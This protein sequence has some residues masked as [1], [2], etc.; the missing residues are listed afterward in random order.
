MAERTARLRSNLNTLTR[1][2]GTGFVASV[3]GGD[4]KALSA[5]IAEAKQAEIPAECN[6]AAEQRLI[7]VFRQFVGGI[8]VPARTLR[9]FIVSVSKI[10]E[11]DGV[12]IRYGNGMV[13]LHEVRP[14]ILRG[15]S[16]SGIVEIKLED[17]R[18]KRTFMVALMNYLATDPECGKLLPAK[19]KGV[20]DRRKLAQLR[21]QNLRWCEFHYRLGPDESVYVLV[22]ENRDGKWLVNSALTEE[23]QQRQLQL[24]NGG[25]ANVPAPRESAA[26]RTAP[27]PPPEQHRQPPRSELP[28]PV[29]WSGQP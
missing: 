14:G 24:A 10:S 13:V 21:Q 28:F 5:A 4:D 8:E 25:A 20:K 15:R 22:L 3:Y 19:L 7:T 2:I 17:D 11:G 1:N 23:L 9:S 12:A 16:D 26:P 27:P 6:S 18:V 29:Q